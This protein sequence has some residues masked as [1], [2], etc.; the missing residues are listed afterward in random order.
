MRPE[1]PL[2]RVHLEVNG[3]GHDLAVAPDASLLDV[4]RD[5]LG[6]TGTRYGCGHGACGACYVLVEGE[7]LAACTL[8]AAD[9]G[10]RRITTIEGLATDGALHPVQ[11]AFID[12]DAMQCGACTPGMIVSAAALL[13]REPAPGEEQIRAAL[14]PHLCRCG[15]Y[16]RAIRAVRRASR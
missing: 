13:A 2:P 8:G 6:L 5:G 7:A 3:V 11:R 15:V 12:E 16:L 9:M 4:L 14:A 10:G 1:P